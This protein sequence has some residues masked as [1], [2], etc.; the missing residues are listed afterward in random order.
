MVALVLL[1]YLKPRRVDLY[2]KMRAVIAEHRFAMRRL[3]TCG[4]VY[5]E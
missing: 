2:K 1:N 5:Y 4:T 3:L